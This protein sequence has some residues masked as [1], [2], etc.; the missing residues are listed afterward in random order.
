M[1]K[2][3]AQVVPI[4]VNAEKEGKQLAE[5]YGVRGFPTILFV[6]G[7]G[8]VM[9][10]I[11]GYLKPDPFAAEMSKAIE[12]SSA[13]AKA[14][15]TLK[16]KPDDGPANSVVAMVLAS[17]GNIEGASAA[18]EKAELAKHDGPEMASAYNA[19]G[20]HHQL[21]GDLDKAIPYFQKANKIAKD[22]EARAYA[23]VSIMVCHKS[24]GDHEAAKKAAKEL[25]ELKGASAEYLDLAK[26]VLEE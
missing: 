11:G 16:S 7:G 14:M 22:D 21:A 2:L 25:L 15:E 13:F 3:A 9:H 4:K 23:R 17:R 18:L 10:K 6:D 1:I 8:E 24:K 20:D 19:L 12:G 26:K 5:K